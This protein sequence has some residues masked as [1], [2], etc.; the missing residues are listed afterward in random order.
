MAT[1]V[2][3]VDDEHTIDRTLT[4]ILR[5]HGFAVNARYDGE[6][7][8]NL[9]M[10]WQPDVFLSG[11]VLPGMSGYEAASQICGVLPQCRVVLL[12]ANPSSWDRPSPRDMGLDFEFLPKPIHVDELLDRLRSAGRRVN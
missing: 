7:A 1:K 6:S 4:L 5:E 11:D 10:K 9:A 8:V 12:S 3:I 2:L